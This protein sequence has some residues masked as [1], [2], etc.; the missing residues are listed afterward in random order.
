M[1][2]ELYY[3]KLQVSQASWR[4][5]QCSRKILCRF[6][7][8]EV[9]SQATVRT[10]WC[11]RP[12]AHQLATSVRT[13]RTFRPDAHQ[14]LETSNCQDYIH[15]DVMEN[16]PAAIKSSRRIQCSSASVRT[17]WQYRPDDI[18]CSTSN[19]VSVSD[20]D[21]G[22]Q[23]QTVRTMWCSRLDAILGKQVQPPRH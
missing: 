4:L 20:T 16:R 11:S 10:M 1:W 3:D 22:R 8:R 19:R 21:M 23:L 12:D 13:T 15:P 9:G 2:K 14:C 5:F 7:L 17:T 6:Q 18:Q